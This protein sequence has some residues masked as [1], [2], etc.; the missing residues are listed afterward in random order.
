MACVTTRK[1]V[2]RGSRRPTCWRRGAL[3]RKTASERAHRLKVDA[4]DRHADR[5]RRSGRRGCFAAIVIL[6]NALGNFCIGARNARAAVHCGFSSDMLL[7]IFT[8]WVVRGISA[9]DPVAAV[10]HG[11]C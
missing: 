8:P 5:A 7:A 11:C 2:R 6:S 9:A 1:Q 4:R 10:A 3:R